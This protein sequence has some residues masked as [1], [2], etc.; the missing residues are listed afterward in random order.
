MPTIS[1]DAQS[2]RYLCFA[3][4]EDIAILRAEGKGVCEI[5]REVGRSPSTISRELR[6][7]A[8]TRGGSWSTGRR[9]EWQ[10]EQRAKRPKAAKLASNARLRDYV[11][12]RLAGEV[13]RPDGARVP[14]P[15]SRG[16]AGATGV[17]STGAGAGRGVRSRSP[18]AWRSTTRMMP[19]CGSRMKRSTSRCMCR[20]AERW[21]AS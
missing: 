17:V 21:L 13:Q 12:E 4:R 5:A 3:E 7:N 8:A 16:K 15:R 14:G 6:R 1:L 2:A 9:G 11:Q 20:V 19:R 10:A 18:G